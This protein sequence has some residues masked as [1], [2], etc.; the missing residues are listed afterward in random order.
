MTYSATVIDALVDTVYDLWVE[1]YQLGKKSER[2]KKL[3]LLA[4]AY[5][6]VDTMDRVLQNPHNLLHDSEYSA[7]EST[8]NSLN[9]LMEQL[10]EKMTDQSSAEITDPQTAVI[11]SIQ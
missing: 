1:F 5:M 7:L 8:R 10:Y 3:V 11:R 6:L 9:L 2:L 4:K